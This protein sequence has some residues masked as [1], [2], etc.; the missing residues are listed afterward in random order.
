VLADTTDDHVEFPAELFAR[1]R[2]W[3]VIPSV[4]LP[5]EYPV[6]LAAV[7]VTVVQLVPSVDRSTWYPLSAA[8]LS[9]QLRTTRGLPVGTVAAAE[10]GAAA[11]VLVTADS[12]ALDAADRTALTR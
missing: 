5:S 3:Y 10:V 1:T 7:V 6:A 2:Y 9:A 8:E 12:Q 4:T 11:G